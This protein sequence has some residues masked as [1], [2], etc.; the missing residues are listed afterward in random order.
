MLYQLMNK[1][2]V[3]ATYEEVKDFD[4]YV[5]L[6]G[7]KIDTDFVAIAREPITSAIRSKLIALKD[8]EYTDPGLDYP[9][10]K[11]DA[12]NRLKDRQIEAILV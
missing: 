7:P 8:F 12:V 5:S 11:L 2:V 1:E 9:T 10:W 4:E 3:I 6:I